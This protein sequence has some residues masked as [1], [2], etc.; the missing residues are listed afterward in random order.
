MDNMKI[1]FGGLGRI[2]STDEKIK[3]EHIDRYRAGE[4]VIRFGIDYLDDALSGIAANDFVLVGAKTGSGKTELVTNIALNAAQAGKRVH[5]F[6]LEAADREI[7]RR[8]KFKVL[9][10]RFRSEILNRFP[11][12]RFCY[13]DWAM[14]LLRNELKDYDLKANDEMEWFYKNLFTY[15]RTH[16]NYTVHDFEKQFQ[17]IKNET[18]LIIIDHLHYFD[19]DNLNENAAI[20]EITKKLKDLSDL[21]GKPI[22][23]VAHLRKTDK[24]FA[25]LVPDIEDFHGSSDIAKIATKA[26]I[27]APAREFTLV[28]LDLKKH[29]W[30]TYARIV[31]S[32]TDSS[33]TIPT[34]VI[35]FDSKINEYSPGYFLGKINGENQWE[36]IPDINAPSW[37]RKKNRDNVPTVF[38]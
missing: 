3:T 33:R 2:T 20:K 30:P 17:A 35:F 15:Y 14:G 21:L 6:A 8:L 4:N 5:F 34:A 29:V 9:A 25:S 37:A 32:R 24:R 31:K 18:D 27:L 28:N 16:G 38:E 1:D 36:S 23:L 11:D 26:I 19:S 22:I 13:Q 12:I 7:E 10:K